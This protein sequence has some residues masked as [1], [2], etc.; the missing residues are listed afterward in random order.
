[1]DAVSLERRTRIGGPG[2]GAAASCVGGYRAPAQ[3]AAAGGQLHDLCRDRIPRRRWKSYIGGAAGA[4]GIFAWRATDCADALELLAPFHAELLP[5]LPRLAPLWTHNDLHAS[6]LLWSDHG[7]DTQRQAIIDF[8][9]ADRTNAVHDLGASPSS[10][11]LW[12]GLRSRERRG[13]SA[14]ASRSS[15]SAARRL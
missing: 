11:T 15:A 1:M 7:R 5:L 4:D 6:N 10:A 8:G 13:R 3:T 2:A 12:S 14:S 9:L